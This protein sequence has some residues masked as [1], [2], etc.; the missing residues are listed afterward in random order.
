MRAVHVRSPGDSPE[1][2]ELPTPDVR[3]GTVLVRVLAASLNPIDSIISRGLLTQSMAHEYP[4]VLGRDASGV[5]EAVGEGVTGIRVGA[6]V[7]GHVPLAPPIGPGTLADFVA[8]PVQAVARK[9]AE[10]SHLA[11]A[12]L[13]LSGTAAI[14]AVDA[15]EPAP[16]QV[17]LVNGASGGVGSFVV[18]LLAARGV[19]VIATGSADDVDRLLRL[20]AAEVIDF[21][22][23]PIAEQVLT[24]RSAGVDALVNLFGMTIDQV[25]LAAVRRGGIVA[26]TTSAPKADMIARDDVRLAS[27]FARPRTDLLDRLARE[28]ADGTLHVEIEAVVPLTEALSRLST[29][30]AGGAHGKVV[31]ELG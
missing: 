24:L 20:G 10:L 19:Q 25:P 18:Q 4:V 15:A 2:G 26:T 8:L 1:L 21:G 13:P 14:E 6:E 23:G 5:V 28:A 3:A 11:A 27:V 9:P 31:V 17:I 22:T 7:F 29:I 12:A 30:A 16:G